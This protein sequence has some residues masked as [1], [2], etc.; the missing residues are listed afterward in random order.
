MLTLTGGNETSSS[1]AQDMS[2]ACDVSSTLNK[3]EMFNTFQSWALQ[4]YGDNGKTKTV[5]RKKY[6]RIVRILTG[7]EKSS[8]ENSKFR[9]WVK[10]KGFRLGPLY[11]H[12]RDGIPDTLLYVPTKQVVV[13][14]HIDMLASDFVLGFCFK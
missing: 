4:N 14:K 13:S 1:A 2:S 12:D 5:T 9:F 7:E 10:A 8:A 6:N 11:K 3:D